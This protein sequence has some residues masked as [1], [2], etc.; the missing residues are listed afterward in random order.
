MTLNGVSPKEME[1]ELY[2]LAAKVVDM[3]AI[4]APGRTNA[5]E[6][7]W[8]NAKSGDLIAVTGKGPE[9]YKDRFAFPAASDSET[10]QYLFNMRAKTRQE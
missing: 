4:I 5:I 3:K 7:A 2:Q 6:F 10:L 1:R 9:P 8:D